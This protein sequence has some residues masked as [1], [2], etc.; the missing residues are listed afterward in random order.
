MFLRCTLVLLS[1]PLLAQAPTPFEVANTFAQAY[2]IWGHMYEDRIV[3]LG[4]QGFDLKEERAW[5]DV[6]AKFRDLQ[7]FMKL[8]YDQ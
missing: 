2:S 6:E 5:K 8:Q 7:K 1:I 4:N 3:G